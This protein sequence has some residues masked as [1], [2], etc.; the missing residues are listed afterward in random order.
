MGG[1]DMIIMMKF[2]RFLF[3]LRQNNKKEKELSHVQSS[4]KKE[5]LA[6]PDP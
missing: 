1:C 4:R 2:C 5:W 3:F 6:D